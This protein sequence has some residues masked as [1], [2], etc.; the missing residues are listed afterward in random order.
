MNDHLPSD[1]LSDDTSWV[2]RHLG[3]AN[4]VPSPGEVTPP[5]PGLVAALVGAE[6]SQDAP[7]VEVPLVRAHR[8]AKVATALV[9]TAAMIGGIVAAGVI[10]TGG[11]SHSVTRLASTQPVFAAASTTEAARTA[12]INLSVTVGAT[13]T[14]VQG[15]ADL[16]TGNADF[17]ADLPAGIGAVEVRV[18]GPVAY[19]HVPS[20][21]Q[22][23]L[24]GKPWM[25]A[26]VATVEALA[27]QQLGLPGFGGGLEFTGVLD[28]LR[29]VSGPVTTDGTT[30]TI[31]GAATTHYHADLDLT[32]AAAN[33]PSG[34]RAKVEQ[35]AQAAGQTIPVDVWIDG[36]GRLRQL[37]ASFDP[38]KVQALAGVTA[39]SPG[40]MVA[41]LDLWG[42]GTPV[43]VT[44]PPADQLS[45]LSGITGA[46]KGLIGRGGLPGGQ[47]GDTTGI[48]PPG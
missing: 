29:G 14:A 5:R 23:L 34:S 48:T 11:A 40:A 20:S 21:V 28:W 42:F 44:P 35:A 31:R 2:R 15:V 46:L 19:V 10:R 7:R 45:A 1:A 8:R 17:T 32:K 37:K 39:R 33:A 27:G 24:G 4:P 38:S 9:G 26:D 22:A 25:K 18:I 3:P 47:G 36:Q 12:Q 6:A 13:V 30:T 41:T 16:S 43:N